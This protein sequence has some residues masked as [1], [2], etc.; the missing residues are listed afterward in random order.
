MR[1]CVL[2][3]IGVGLASQAAGESPRGR[4][5]DADGLT[6]VPLAVGQEADPPQ[7]DERRAQRTEK[8]RRPKG[9]AAERA[10]PPDV[11][12]LG[13]LSWVLGRPTD[14]SVTVSVL[15]AGGLEGYCEYGIAS[16]DYTRKTGMVSFSPGKPVVLM[17]DQLS[18]DKQCFY[19]L[20]YRKPGE[21]AFVEGAEHSFH[22]QRAPGSTFTFVIQGD[23]HPERPQMFAPSLYAQS[24]RE[25][26]KA[27]GGSAMATGM[28]MG[29]SAIPLVSGAP[30][31]AVAPSASKNRSSPNILVLIA[32]DLG[33]GDL[34]LHHG[35][36]RTPQ[37]D[38]LASD[39]VELQRFY[40]YP[41]C[42]PTRAAFL[43]GQMP[44]RFGI[45][46]PLGPREPGLP[47][48][49]PTLPRTLR[50][51]GCQTFLVGKW[52]VGSQGPPL[53]SGFDH[54]YGF[55]GPEV[56]YFRHTGR[57]RALDWQRNGQPVEEPGYS[58]FLF[59]DE[60]IR[61]LE[62]RDVTRPF[63]LE[64]AFNAPHFP[65]SAPDEYLAKY[66]NQSPSQATYA[67]LVDALD[68]AIG[69]VLTSLDK[70]ELRDNTLVVFFSDN[71]AGGREGGSN[72]P[73]RAGK[74]TVFEGGIHVPCLMRWPGHIKADT[75]SQQPL[76]AQDLFPTLAAAAGVPVKDAPK[77]DGKNI[78]D[79]LCSGRVQDRG[80]FVIAGTDF[81]IFDG[82]WKLI[83]TS[84]GKR[85]LYQIAKD[86]GET[87]DLY[88]SSADIA[89]RLEATLAEVKKDLPAVRVRPRP[90]PG[91][92]RGAGGPGV[93]R[94]EPTIGGA[95]P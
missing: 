41:V 92:R 51:A 64:V 73:F 31:N 87:T 14:R 80:A 15:F 4:G 9:D 69:R 33:W 1:W 29:L 7:G 42:S 11:A 40:V 8:Q 66:K 83:E 71:G 74:G 84:D 39:G 49:L 55:M 26:L 56:D 38:Q 45:A 50:S 18:S 75:V 25:F 70:Q 10:I 77:L 91:N 52:H 65:L 61:L 36:P 60:A 86:P 16:G 22:T 44:R 62:K 28:L 30:D 34:T 78:W 23:S 37:L 81:A 94:S 13:R 57:S 5:S 89:R 21:G 6:V 90:G 85:S 48:G 2:V 76:A 24:R 82:D 53:Q 47:A 72:G 20:R 68:T 59:A 43:T 63:F 88:S 95:A 93:G 54:F 79:P 27:A 12:A 58:T 46:Y 32:D 17:L 19:R 67:A 35:V 3:L